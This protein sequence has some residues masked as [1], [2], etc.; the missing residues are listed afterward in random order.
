MSL[1]REGQPA[2]SLPSRTDLRPDRGVWGAVGRM[3]GK[4]RGEFGPFGGGTRPG[5]WVAWVAGK[6]HTPG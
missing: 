2:L 4:G 3:W 5:S 1:P 6:G